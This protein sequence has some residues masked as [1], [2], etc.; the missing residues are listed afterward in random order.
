[1]QDGVPVN[2][3]GG[4][5]GRKF[6]KTCGDMPSSVQSQCGDGKAYQVNDQGW[7]VWVGDG[8]TLE[9]R[10]HE[11]PLGH[12]APGR[13]VAVELSALLRS[14]DRRSSAA[15]SG[16]AKA[17]AR[18]TSSAARSRVSALR[19]TTRS[20]TSGSRSTGCSTARSETTSTTRVK[21]GAC[22]TS[23]RTTSTRASKT[24]ET[25]KPVGYGWRVGGA[26]GRRRRRVLR[27]PRT[28]QLQHRR[29]VVRQD[30]R[31]ERH[32]PTRPSSWCRWRLDARRRRSKRVHV[33]ASTRATI[34]KSAWT[35]ATRAQA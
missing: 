16:W 30:S 14:P 31:D 22:W 35:A 17:P 5:W 33:H 24:V 8:N 27:P 21:A 6:Y 25:A 23:P 9:G 7:V 20:P 4:I 29:R 13:A 18:A 28:E 34:P 32:V 1:M 19:G 10:H 15:R 26:G 3:Y 12:E 11:E 2:Q